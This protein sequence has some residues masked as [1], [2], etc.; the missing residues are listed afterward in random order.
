MRNRVRVMCKPGS[1]GGLG[2]QPPRS[3]RTDFPLKLSQSKLGPGHFVTLWDSGFLATAYEALNR[4]AEAEALLRD[5][6]ARRRKGEKPNSPLLASDLA[7]LGRN[8]LMQSK[9]TEAESILRECLV[10]CEKVSADDWKRYDAM[11]LLGEAI[12]GQTRYAEAE[13]MVIDG[14][15]GLK[16]RASRVTVPDRFRLREAAVRVVRLY[17]AWSK[18]DTAME[19]KAKLGMPDLPAQVLAWP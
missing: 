14:Y 2:G 4:W 7:Q 10:I 15:M 1:V 5:T 11:S 19:W 18:P 3:T 9:W 16:E 6:L 13:P 8:L 12:L 17:E